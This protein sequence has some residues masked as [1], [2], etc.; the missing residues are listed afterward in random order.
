MP[1]KSVKTPIFTIAGVDIR[2]V[3]GC[4]CLRLRMATRRITQLYETCLAPTDLTIG[5]FGVL[6]NLFGA[7]ATGAAGVPIG[8][9]AERLGVDPTTLKRTLG[10]L[11]GDGLAAAATDETDRRVRLIRLTD[12][13]R[14]RLEQAV[15]L[16][17]RAQS[18]LEAALGA[19]TRDALDRIVGQAY[20]KAVPRA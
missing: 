18:Q 10:P 11:V 2:D 6:A 9:L 7:A 4:S 16:W 17:Q 1:G 15:P 5:Q 14:A 8:T 13:G 19:G 3:G 12:A 20:E